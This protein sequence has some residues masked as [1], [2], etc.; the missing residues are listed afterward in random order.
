MAKP[1][2]LKKLQRNFEENFFKIESLSG[3][4]LIGMTIIA[5]VWANSWW[6]D[7][8][9]AIWK[10][11]FGIETSDFGLIKPLHLWI[12]DGL[13]AVFFFLI[14]LEIKR[15]LIVGEL[16]TR[17]KAAFPIF[18]ALGGM[19]IPAL[20]YVLLNNR[21]ETANGWAIPVATDIAFSLAILKLLG[22]RIPLNLKIFLTAFAIVDDLGAVLVIALFY[23]TGV[24]WLSILIGLAL[25]GGL[26]FIFKKAYSK[27]LLVIVGMVVWYLFLK[28]GVHPTIAGVLLAITVPIRQ[29]VN[30]GE[31]AAEFESIVGRLNSAPKE[32]SGLLSKDQIDELDYLEE[33]TD[34]VQSPLQHL[35]HSLHNWVAYFIMPVFALTNAGVSIGADTSI[36]YYLVFMIATALIVGKSVGISAISLIV[37]KMGYAKLPDEVSPKQIVGVTFL[38]GIGFT[39]SIF[40]ANLAFAHDEQLLDSAKV[41]ILIGSF[42]SAVLGYSLLK[43]NAIRSHRASA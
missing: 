13:M 22:N 9:H 36:D 20:L 42:V 3:L 35:E 40:I 39:M 17:Q 10:F 11:R 5:L 30:V 31:F 8:Y 28:G 12:N 2:I 26:Y 33:L 6:A 7:S 24:N 21:P 38:A 43:W 32:A 18:A 19:A 15:E 23:S 16:D 1:P 29:R 41:G 37:T 4:L 14:G 34:K 27:Y 25:I